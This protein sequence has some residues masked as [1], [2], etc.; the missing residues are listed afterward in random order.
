MGIALGGLAS[1]TSGLELGNFRLD[2]C[3]ASPSLES[4]LKVQVSVTFSFAHEDLAGGRYR[5]TAQ[6]KGFG[7]SLP[8]HK[9][10]ARGGGL[11]CL[12]GRRYEGPSRSWTI[13]RYS[14][15]RQ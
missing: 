14:R 12:E 4:D 3:G 15:E 13:Q 11:A 7:A 5:S 1:R 8:C 6:I 2:L 9:G 10:S